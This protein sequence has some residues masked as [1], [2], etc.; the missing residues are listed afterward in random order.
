[1]TTKTDVINASLAFVSIA[2]AALALQNDRNAWPFE[3][4]VHL[5][6]ET[7]TDPF[8]RSQTTR[9]L[10]SG[11]AGEAWVWAVGINESQRWYPLEPL[12]RA[13]DDRWTSDVNAER[14]AP[15]ARLCVVRVDERVSQD[16]LNY[17][18]DAQSNSRI[19]Q[20]GVAR[21]SGMA[22]DDCATAL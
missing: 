2:V 17:L 21:P 15:G 11:A 10:V 22:E 8:Q 12:Q 1:M 6:I 9:L 5:Q 4:E 13:S 7:P 14:I 20:D 18:R 19:Y 3:K 16:F